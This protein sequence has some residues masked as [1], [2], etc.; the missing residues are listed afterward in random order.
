M[1]KCLRYFNKYFTNSNT[2]KII[3]KHAYDT[4]LSENLTASYPYILVTQFS[5]DC[6]C[7]NR[8]N[9]IPRGGTPCLLEQGANVK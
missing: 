2:V 3:L 5:M 1:Q 4:A 6:G 9:F 7:S 8:P